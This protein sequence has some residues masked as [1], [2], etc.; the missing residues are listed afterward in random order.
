MLVLLLH[1]L[2]ST[3][4]GGG[5]SSSAS[6]PPWFQICSGDKLGNFG[7]YFTNASA[8]PVLKPRTDSIKFFIGSVKS[9][10]TTVSG[11]YAAIADF[12]RSNPSVGIDIEAGGLRGFNCDGESYA[13]E[14]LD[15][16]EPLLAGGVG[17]ALSTLHITFDGPFAHSL[18]QDAKP[19]PLTPQQV[20]TEL[21]KN[22]R[23]TRQLG[24]QRY[25]QLAVAFHWNEPVPWYRVGGSFPAFHNGTVKDF[26]DLLGLLDLVTSTPGA[27]FAAF[28]ADSP[29]V[30]NHEPGG[31]YPKLGALMAAVR[32]KGL[33]FGHYFNT[34]PK[35]A[36]DFENGTLADASE[37]VAAL[38]NPDHAIVESWYPFPHYALPEGAADTFA[39]TALAAWSIFDEAGGGAYLLACPTCATTVFDEYCEAPRPLKAAQSGALPGTPV[40]TPGMA[41]M[42]DA[43]NK[44]AA[45]A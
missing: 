18:H 43:I 5:G 8:W 17:S 23:T 31:G 1:A 12:L 14:T 38:G 22:I 39:H 28:H 27:D 40:C 37:F 32:A 15:M 24:A 10:P 21:A 36:G 11:G 25:P 26:G 45:A 34:V 41:A 29:Y 33:A 20:A 35:H 30:Y 9:L 44:T 4:A 3:T 7:Q 19:C 16:I 13:K 6:S 42:V 2:E